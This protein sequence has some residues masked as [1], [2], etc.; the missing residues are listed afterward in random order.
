MKEHCPLVRRHIHIHHFGADPQVQHTG[1]PLRMG[2]RHKVP[3]QVVQDRSRLFKLDWP[4]V[5]IKVPPI[6]SPPGRS[7]PRPRHQPEYLHTQLFIPLMDIQKPFGNLFPKNG[8]RRRSQPREPRVGRLCRL[9]QR[10]SA[11][12]SA[13]HDDSSRPTPHLVRTN[14]AYAYIH[15]CIALQQAH[16]PPVVPLQILLKLLPPDRQR[17]KQVPHRNRRAHRPR[18]HRLPPQLAMLVVLEFDAA[19]LVSHLGH[20]RNV[21]DGTQRAQRLPTKTQRP[22]RLQV[23]KLGYLGC[24]VLPGKQRSV[25]RGDPRPVV[26]HLHERLAIIAQTNVQRRRIR[27]ECVIHKLFDSRCKVGDDLAGGQPVNGGLV[28]WLNGP[29][30]HGASFKFPEA[31]GTP[32]RSK[33]C[34]RSFHVYRTRN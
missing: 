8:F 34:D 16:Q 22:Q 9:G 23:I 26:R 33:S 24:V 1:R 19:L 12:R 4:G 20:H 18:G 7:R 29:V 28:D 21:R 3:I 25:R 31:H 6:A 14:K 32:W 15:Q 27:I 11:R 17:M 10:Q 5:H 13:L 2:G 30:R